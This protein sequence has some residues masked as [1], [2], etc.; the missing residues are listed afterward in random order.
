M[1]DSPCGVVVVPGGVARWIGGG[2]TG[3]ALRVVLDLGRRK[4]FP[5]GAVLGRPKGFPIGVVVEPG[6]VARW[7]GGGATGAT[8]R[9][10]LDLGRRKGFPV[11]AEV[12]PADRLDASAAGIEAHGC[13]GFSVVVQVAAMGDSPC[14]VIVVPGGIAGRIGDGNPVVPGVVLEAGGLARGVCHAGDAA[15]H[16]ILEPGR[17]PCRIGGEEASALRIRL[18]PEGGRVADGIRGADQPAGCVV[19]VAGGAAGIVNNAGTVIPGVVLIPI[20]RVASRVH[21]PDRP[22]GGVVRVAKGVVGYCRADYVR[23][24]DL[25]SGRAGVHTLLLHVPIGNLAGLLLRA[26]RRRTRRRSSLRRGNL[27]PDQAKDGGLTYKLHV[28]E[29]G[30][31]LGVPE[32]GAGFATGGRGAGCRGSAR[33]RADF[34]IELGADAG[35]RIGLEAGGRTENR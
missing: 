31:N 6:G 12:E 33:A 7:I 21:H 20:G 14:G 16:V 17:L 28:G 19:L 9:V 5:V 26:A 2:A 4:G 22:P 23:L 18:V 10:V 34:V 30:G 24:D 15:G 13:G 8:L 35:R 25:P 29:S 3:A 11:G 27:E 1:G 32:G